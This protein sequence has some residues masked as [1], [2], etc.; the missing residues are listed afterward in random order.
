MLR[1][2]GRNQVLMATARKKKDKPDVRHPRKTLLSH[3]RSFA[4]EQPAHLRTALLG[5]R[6]P[7]AQA[8][9]EQQRTAH[10][11]PPRSRVRARHQEAALPGGLHDSRRAREIES[12][13]ASR[14]ISVRIALPGA[15]AHR[16]ACGPCATSST[17]SSPSS[18]PSA[19]NKRF[20]HGAR[21]L[22]HPATLYREQR[23][24][25]GERRRPTRA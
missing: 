13:D 18:R 4:P 22:R 3:W 9:Q 16:P 1:L 15:S 23:R 12:R 14:K 21:L 5:D 17:K 25:V 10:V 24:A 8:Q 6:V 11:P 19:A 2:A 20:R 7:A